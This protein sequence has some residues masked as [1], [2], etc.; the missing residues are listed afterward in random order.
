[1]EKKICSKCKVEKYVTEFYKSKANVANDGLKYSCKVCSGANSLAWSRANKDI[2]SKRRKARYLES[3]GGKLTRKKRSPEEARE[4]FNAKRRKRYAEDEEY[5]EKD[6]ASRRQH[7][8]DNRDKTL[9]RTSQYKKE[10]PEKVA[11]WKSNRRVRK[12]KNGGTFTSEEWKE[13]CE[14]YD[15]MCVCCRKERK[16]TVDHVVPISLGGNG[17]IENIQPLCKSCNSRKG[18]RSSADYR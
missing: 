3:V 12:A 5:R 8:A 9:E 14:R 17:Y 4:R 6:K 13:L 2:I 11:I 16:L 18:N 15:N 7:Y 10:N 1:M